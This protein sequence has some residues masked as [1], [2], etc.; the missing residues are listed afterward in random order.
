MYPTKAAKLARAGKIA[1]IINDLIVV[2]LQEADDVIKAGRDDQDYVRVEIHVLDGAYEQDVRKVADFE[3]HFG[4]DTLAECGEQARA[5]IGK[6]S[7]ITQIMPVF[8]QFLT[9][10]QLRHID[11]NVFHLYLGYIFSKAGAKGGVGG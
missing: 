2:V 7:L 4:I 6:Q 8:G 1:N 9:L 3:I 11:D 10:N 5:L